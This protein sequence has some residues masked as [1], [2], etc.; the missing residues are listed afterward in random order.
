M[1]LR[2]KH[3]V[4]LDESDFITHNLRYMLN[5]KSR[6]LFYFVFFIGC[7]NAVKANSNGFS[8]LIF[9]SSEENTADTTATNKGI[10]KATLKIN[11]P[12]LIDPLRQSLFFASDIKVAGSWSID[13]GAGWFFNRGFDD[14]FKGESY[15]GLRA[16]LGFKYYYMEKKRNNYNN[17]RKS[18]IDPYL[19]F[20]AK[21]NF[22]VDSEYE[23][24]CRYGCQY[25]ETLILAENHAVYGGAFKTGL[26]V[27]MGEKKRMFFDFYTGIGYRFVNISPGKLPADA[28]RLFWQNNFLSLQR[29][30]GKYH[31]PDF[32]L[33][34]YLGYKF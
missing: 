13:A 19:G 3:L 11:I 24:L 10:A 23:T 8:Q 34:F 18:N 33:G 17:G 4:Q 31:L 28:E 2:I 16:R 14:K 6:L 25:Q 30:P 32:L 26:H 9:P 27:Y 5:M 20:E 21:Y 15:S 7:G 22:I 29:T 1:W 12:C